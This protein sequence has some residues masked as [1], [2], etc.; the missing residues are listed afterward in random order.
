MSD[1][2]T[3]VVTGL[4]GGG[5]GEQI[6]K[7]LR[8]S[9]LQYRIVGCDVTKISKGLQEVD[10]PYLV[11]L[12]VDSDYVTSVLAVCRKEAARALFPGSEPELR[13]LSRERGRLEQAGVFCPMNPESVIDLCLDKKR[14]MEGIRDRGFA[15]P[16]TVAVGA[17]D[18]LESVDFLPAVLKPSTGGGGSSDV[19]VAQTKAELRSIAEVLLAARRDLVVQEYVGR[20]EDEYTVGVLV[21]MDG[22]LLHSIGMRRSIL[23]A[24]SNRLRMPNRTGREELGPVLAISSGISQGEVGPFPE[25]TRPC[26]DLALALGCRGATNFQCRLVGGRPSFFEI[27]PR[28]SGTT[29]ARA[30]FGFNEPD[31]LFRRH[32]LGEPIAPRFAYTEGH[33]TRGLAEVRVGDRSVPSARALE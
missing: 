18:D 27:N 3:V 1:G 9:T 5:L 32:V 23:S 20:P 13:A 19:Y 14:T 30:L 2:P 33:V 28:F 22:E 6:L 12:A 29:S 26:E 17:P 31:L 15:C 8:L 4:G 16:R 7:A 11:P 10:A 25:V 21:A 24:L